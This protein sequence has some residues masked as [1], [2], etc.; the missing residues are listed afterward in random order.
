[1][2]TSQSTRKGKRDELNTSE[3]DKYWQQ[4]SCTQIFAKQYL[5]L[6]NIIFTMKE[7]S[8]NIAILSLFLG[9]VNI[10]IQQKISPGR[11]R[12]HLFC[13]FAVSWANFLHQRHSFLLWK[14]WVINN[15]ESAAN[16]VWRVY[17]MPIFA[18]FYPCPLL[19]YS[20][21]TE[22]EAQNALYW[23]M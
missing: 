1:M 16:I 5:K 10:F 2:Y 7:A 13:T 12:L 22:T 9:M 18:S 20:A 21:M 3:W 19:T 23:L 4:E 8:F 6:Y 17:R 14:I 11:K 15:S